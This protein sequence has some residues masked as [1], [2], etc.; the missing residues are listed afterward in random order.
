MTFVYAFKSSVVVF[1]RPL[2]SA[3][4]FKIISF[5]F[6]NRCN[7]Q[8][9]IIELK[10]VFVFARHQNKHLFLCTNDYFNVALID[11]SSQSLDEN[12]WCRVV[13]IA[14][15][16]TEFAFWRSLIV[17]T[18]TTTG[19]ATRMHRWIHV[20]IHCFSTNFWTL[21]YT[22]LIFFSFFFNSRFAVKSSDTFVFF[23]SNDWISFDRMNSF[24]TATT[25]STK[26]I[27]VCV[28]IEFCRVHSS[29]FRQEKKKLNILL[30]K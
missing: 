19:Q 5:V 21:F 8:N 27:C 9:W 28:S 1:N 13:L 17:I 30:W 25:S 29:H 6:S 12:F 16:I 22:I 24:M 7:L 11:D 18:T 4:Q 26:R 20:W 3:L 2:L 14:F 15:E 10:I 23:W